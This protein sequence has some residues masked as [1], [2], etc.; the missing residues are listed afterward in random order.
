VSVPFE[1][2]IGERVY[3]PGVYGFLATRDTIS[4][5]DKHGNRLAMALANHVSGRSR[6]KTGQVV[7]EC[8]AKQCFLSQL[9]RPTQEDGR[10]LLRSRLE[11]ELAA[12][13]SGTYMALAG[14]E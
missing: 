1:F 6:G 5:E 8:Y 12:K 10:E 2:F 3:E 11:S 13:K 14:S 4:I 9:W 7:S